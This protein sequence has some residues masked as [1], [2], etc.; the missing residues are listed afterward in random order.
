MVISLAQAAFIIAA[1]AGNDNHDRMC[2][3][4]F[5]IFDLKDNNFTTKGTKNTK[6]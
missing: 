2:D 4:R 6:G 1:P 3:F 5:P